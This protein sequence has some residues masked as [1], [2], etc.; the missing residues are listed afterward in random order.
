MSKP[1]ELNEVL[2]KVNCNLADGL[3]SVVKKYMHFEDKG[4]G[5]GGDD[6]FVHDMSLPP[7]VE[8]SSSASNP[9]LVTKK[10]SGKHWKNKDSDLIC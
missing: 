6:K 9:Q 7:L 2:H 10:K 3:V 5:K 1:G 8:V 4:A